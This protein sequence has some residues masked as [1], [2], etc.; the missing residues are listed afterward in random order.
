MSNKLPKS[1]VPFAVPCI[2][3][4]EIEAVVETILCLFFLY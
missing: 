1:F 3:D 2:G 4:Q